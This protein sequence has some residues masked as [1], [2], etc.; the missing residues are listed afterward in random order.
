MGRLSWIIQLGPKCKHLYPY[1]KETERDLYTQRIKGYEDGAAWVLKLLT[2]RIVLMKPQAKK[3][4][5]PL[6]T[7]RDKEIILLQ[8][9]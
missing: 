6:E 7:G 1:K 3:S 8:S 5:L 4:Q 2:L 9:L